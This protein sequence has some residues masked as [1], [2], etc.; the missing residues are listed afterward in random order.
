M[1]TRLTGAAETLPPAGTPA[2]QRADRAPTCTYTNR[3]ANH[4]AGSH[5]P[6]RTASLTV[7]FFTGKWDQEDPTSQGRRGE[8]T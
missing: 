4:S 2:P 6:R 8:E 7:G 5:W 1:F 3:A